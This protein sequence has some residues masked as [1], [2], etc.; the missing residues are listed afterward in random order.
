M[1]RKSKIISA[2]LCSLFCV[3]IFA[4]E[5]PSEEK[6]PEIP[7]EK[8]VSEVIRN[9]ALATGET[10][11]ID[12]GI[13]SYCTIIRKYDWA[14]VDLQSMK[15]NLTSPWVWDNNTFFINQMAHPTMGTFYF[16]A[17]RANDLGF[18]GSAAEAALGSLVWELFGERG[19]ASIN[20]FI[21]T[22]TGG[23]VW[24]ET[25]FRISDS[26][27]KIHPALGWITNP[28]GAVTQLVIGRRPQN[29]SGFISDMDIL[30]FGG[31]DFFTTKATF[32]L[33]TKVVYGVPYGHITDQPFDQ[34]TLLVDCHFAEDSYFYRINSS[35]FLQSWGFGTEERPGNFGITMGY[36]CINGKDYVLS[37]GD[38]AFGIR[39]KFNFDQETYFAYGAETGFVFM[40]APESLKYC[41]GPEVKLSLAFENKD[42][43]KLEVDSKAVFLCDWPSS[44]SKKMKAE[45]NFVILTDISY[46]HKIWKNISLGISDSA[47]CKIAEMPE[48]NQWDNYLKLFVKVNLIKEH[49]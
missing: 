41:L 24:G 45:N 20:D 25:L 36:D 5:I 27:Y 40:A 3:S 13:N 39:Q 47:Y 46:V 1:I 11:L 22:T 28:V 4:E 32:G 48:R 18:Y 42:F 9:V 15:K 44:V 17:G 16:D 23:I 33:G 30:T 43:G 31:C 21:S 37:L 49:F 35:G 2:V 8:T 14:R 34:F 38:L 12:L 6:H 29:V 10:L 19:S 26:L 7:H